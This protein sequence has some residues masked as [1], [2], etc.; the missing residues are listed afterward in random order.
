MNKK[1][2]INFKSKANLSPS[3]SIFKTLPSPVF[4]SLE[5]ER[6]RD[7]STKPGDADDE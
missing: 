4:C 5:K 1:Y 6:D 3:T 2:E 7:H